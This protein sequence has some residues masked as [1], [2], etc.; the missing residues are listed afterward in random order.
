MRSGR[1]TGNFRLSAATRTRYTIQ[2]SEGDM[3]V[4]RTDR[5]VL[6]PGIFAVLVATLVF[7]PSAGLLAH[8]IPNDVTVQTFLK[9]EGQRLRLLLRVPLQAMRDLDYARRGREFVDLDQ[10]ERSLRDAATLWVADDI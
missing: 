8:D 5:K 2:I 4:T 1:R 7:A 9:P 3:F 6:I 10:V